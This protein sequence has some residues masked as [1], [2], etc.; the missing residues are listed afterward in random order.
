MPQVLT[1][2]GREG[3]IFA[4]N[5][6]AARVVWQSLL[7]AA[8]INCMQKF[9]RAAKPGVPTCVAVTKAATRSCA[10]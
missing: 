10:A 1:A 3:R 2:G 5:G 6:R 9:N 7:W 4:R 8:S